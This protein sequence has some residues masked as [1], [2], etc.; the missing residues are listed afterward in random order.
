VEIVFRASVTFLLMFLITRG[1]SKRSLGD[2]SPFEMLLLVTLGDI[3][4][5][6]VTQEDYSLTGSALALST[7]AF[8]ITVLTWITWKSDRGR[9]ILEGVPIVLVRDGEPVDRALAVE[10]MP[11]DE[12]LEAA[13]QEGVED[14][15]DIKVAV[16]EVNG[17]ISIIKTSS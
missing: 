9:R 5:Q 7:F 4:Q 15:A 13:R 10:R 6:G 1:L 11:L 16:L 2:M 8:W 12:V 14:I 17:R 3:V